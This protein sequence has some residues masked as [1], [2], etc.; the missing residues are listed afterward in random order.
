MEQSQQEGHAATNLI[1]QLLNSGVVRDD[2]EGSII[3]P[4]A[5]GEKKFRPFQENE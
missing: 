1:T 4:T 5:D 2:G 3:I